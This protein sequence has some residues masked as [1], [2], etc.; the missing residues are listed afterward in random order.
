MGEEIKMTTELNTFVGKNIVDNEGLDM[1]KV[2][3]EKADNEL[4]VSVKGYPVFKGDYALADRVLGILEKVGCSLRGD[5]FKGE[6][7]GEEDFAVS[8]VGTYTKQFVANLKKLKGLK[9][10]KSGKEFLL[11]KLNVINSSFE[12]KTVESFVNKVTA[13]LE[14]VLKNKALRETLGGF[15]AVVQHEETVEE[16]ADALISAYV[17]A[18]TFGASKY[19]IADSY[20]E[21]IEVQLRGKAAEYKM[22]IRK[23]EIRKKNAKSVGI[24]ECDTRIE[25]YE[26]QRQAVKSTKSEL[27]TLMRSDKNYEKMMADITAMK[28]MVGFKYGDRLCLKTKKDRRE[29]EIFNLFCF[30]PGIEHE[31]TDC[32]QDV[33]KLGLFDGTRDGGY[34]YPPQRSFEVSE[35]LEMAD[36]P[37][38]ILLK[39]LGEFGVQ[40]SKRFINKTEHEILGSSITLRSQFHSVRY[41]CE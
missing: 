33:K 4:I 23:N 26:R 39:L 30:M 32:L 20:D 40:G 10:S 16:F 36:V 38:N 3:A 5:V 9:E 31:G 14:A 28:N 41:S 22:T 35:L 17:D 37:L 8:I 19:R 29:K 11:E 6:Y 21:Y 25:E 2:I 12:I 7:K 13:S 34:S 1:D 27:E 18:R 24:I 15:E